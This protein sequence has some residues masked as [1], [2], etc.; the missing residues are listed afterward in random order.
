MEVHADKPYHLH[1]HHRYY[2]LDNFPWE[3]PDE[4]LVTLCNWCHWNFHQNNKVPVYKDT[5]KLITVNL[6]P[7]RRCVGAGHLP[8]YNHVQNGV[9]FECGGAKYY[10]LIH[11][12]KKL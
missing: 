12:D 8:N 11:R 6:T 3:Y 4:A 1:I 9:C 2:I 7:C 5:L 10:E